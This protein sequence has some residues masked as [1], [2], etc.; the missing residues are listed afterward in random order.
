[1]SSKEGLG[2]PRCGAHG[3]LY[4]PNVPDLYTSVLGFNLTARVV[5]PED[6]MTVAFLSCANKA[7]DIAFVDYP[8]P[9]KF[10]HALFLLNTWEE[11]FRGADIMGTHC[12]PVDLGPTGHGIT[13]GGTIYSFDPCGN[14]NEMLCADYMWYADREPNA[15][16]AEEIG[17]AIF[18]YDRKR[19]ES[20]LTVVT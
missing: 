10:H 12:I 6:V 1:M 20:F 5:A 17:K 16:D 13:R 14:R 7:H 18:Y 3:L 11:V 4:R 2:K 9:N 8:E 19:N 15:R